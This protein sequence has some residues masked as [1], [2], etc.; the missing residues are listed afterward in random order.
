MTYGGDTNV[1]SSGRDVWQGP[2]AEGAAS[3]LGGCASRKDIVDANT[4]Q[5]DPLS[6]NV[7]GLSCRLDALPLDRFT[8][9]DELPIGEIVQE[10]HR[11]ARRSTEGRPVL[12]LV[13]QM[14]L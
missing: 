11:Q 4:C 12:Q 5:S 10:L 8:P 3:H 7:L 2:P 1:G 9:G 13:V 6:P 14:R